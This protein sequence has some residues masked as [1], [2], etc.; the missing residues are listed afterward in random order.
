MLFRYII[1]ANDDNYTTH[2]N[3]LYAQNAEFINAEAGTTH[4]ATTVI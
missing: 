3:T 2:I 1:S 4:I